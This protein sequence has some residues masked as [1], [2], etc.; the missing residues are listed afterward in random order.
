LPPEVI[1]KVL[2]DKAGA[3]KSCYQK[4]LQSNPD[5]SGSI[6]IKFVI[7]PAGQV[8]G[9]KVENSSLDS[10]KVQECITTL[11]KSLRFPQAKGG[12]I[13]T[14]NKTFTFKSN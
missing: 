13:T 9:V 14:V 3:V 10:D 11:I 1:K 8:V 12:G 2:A 4:E 6:K 5:L 7:N